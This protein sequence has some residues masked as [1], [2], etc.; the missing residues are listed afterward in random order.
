MKG[1]GGGSAGKCC[2]CLFLKFG[3]HLVFERIYFDVF[4]G[5]GSSGTGAT[6]DGTPRV[7]TLSWKRIESILEGYVDKIK[8]RTARCRKPHPPS[9]A[10]S[11]LP[12]YLIIYFIF[13]INIC[14][15]CLPVPFS[16][17]HLHDLL[18]FSR[19]TMP[20]SFQQLLHIIQRFTL[21]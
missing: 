5:A 20:L 18:P 10:H 2:V 21:F 4:R 17:G 7:P 19:D 14:F 16:E 3:M 1:D 9:I 13:R 15:E 11:L 8:S 6:V 12:K